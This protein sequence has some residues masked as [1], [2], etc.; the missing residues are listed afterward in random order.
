MDEYV[1]TPEPAGE[2]ELAHQ[3]GKEQKLEMLGALAGFIAHDLN[4]EL[5]VILGN[6]GLALDALDPDHPLNEGLLEAQRACHRCVDMTRAL[7]TF[8]QGVKPELKPIELD[9]LLKTTEASCV[10]SFPPLFQPSSPNTR[11]CRRSWRMQP[12]SSRSS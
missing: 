3:L 9:P 7:L 5:T 10:K 8:G 11:I 2:P 1:T 6:V 12:R 4:N